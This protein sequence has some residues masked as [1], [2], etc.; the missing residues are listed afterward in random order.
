MN[1]FQCHFEPAGKS[2]SW[3][4]YGGSRCCPPRKVNISI[5]LVSSASPIT[6]SIRQVMGTRCASRRPDNTWF[7]GLPREQGK[8]RKIECRGDIK[9]RKGKD[10]GTRKPTPPIT[11]RSH[12]NPMWPNMFCGS[13]QLGG[14]RR[15]NQWQQYHQNIR[16]PVECIRTRRIISRKIRREMLMM[17]MSFHGVRQ[18]G[19]RPSN[20]PLSSCSFALLTTV[21]LSAMD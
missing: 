3:L 20:S 10:Y 14:S 7:R 13:W 19:L 2:A 11:R 9:G 16:I 12:T 4:W 5:F 21:Y 8:A 6:Y 18:S 17:E 1:G 15:P